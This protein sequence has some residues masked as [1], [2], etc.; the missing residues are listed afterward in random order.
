MLSAGKGVDA[1]L[2]SGIRG[3][4][5]KARQAERLIRP[6]GIL[7]LFNDGFYGPYLV[8]Q[9]AALASHQHRDWQRVDRHLRATHR[10]R[11]T[12]EAD[13]RER[14]RADVFR[15]VATGALDAVDADQ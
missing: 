12:V 13:E 11:V 7:H 5:D 4:I 9:I 1:F 3:A 15:W 2:E 6:D 10:H 14:L 8:R